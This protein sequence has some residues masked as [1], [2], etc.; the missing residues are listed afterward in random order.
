MGEGDEVL[1]FARVVIEGTERTCCALEPA[2]MGEAKE[3]DTSATPGEHY[4]AA[5]RDWRE[6]LHRDALRA[7]MQAA[8]EGRPWRLAGTYLESCNCEVI[9]PC[10]RVTGRAVERPTYGIC[11]GALS[12]AINDGYVGDVPLSGLAVVLA[13]RYD[14]DEPGSLWDFTLYLDDRADESQQAILEAVFTGRLG[15]PPMMQFP[16]A[17]KASR[18]RATRSVPI[19]VEHFARRGGFRAGGYVSVRV[20]EPVGRS[21]RVSSLIPGHDRPGIERHGDRLRVVDDTLTFEHRKR[22]A[23]ESTFD[24]V[25]RHAA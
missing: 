20:G 15:G 24:Y 11:E 23:Y 4:D 8:S 17:F 13:F 22:C 5:L 25:E 1:R 14:A 3:R 19:T 2:A 10:R 12:W 7:E 16:W 18:P 9:C 6:A 21:D